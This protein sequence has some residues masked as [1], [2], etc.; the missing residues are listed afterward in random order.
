LALD[1][2]P[3]VVGDS[4]HEHLLAGADHVTILPQLG[5]DFGIGI[6][7]LEKIAPA[8]TGLG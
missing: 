2:D 5:S 8:V 6:D 1:P 3:V 4:A 7:Q